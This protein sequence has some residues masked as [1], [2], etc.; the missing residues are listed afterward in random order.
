MEM[1]HLHSGGGLSWEGC[2]AG[3]FRR[4]VFCLSTSRRS[5]RTAQSGTSDSRT[6]H[7]NDGNSRAA[8]AVQEGSNYWNATPLVGRTTTELALRSA[9][10]CCDL[11]PL[12]FTARMLITMQRTCIW[13]IFACRQLHA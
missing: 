11:P 5:S 2:V 12:R 7:D 6:T 1:W 3:T 9:F 4:R 10:Y 13:S 8:G